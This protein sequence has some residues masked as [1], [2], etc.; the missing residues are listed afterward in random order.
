M[1]DANGVLWIRNDRKPFAKVTDENIDVALKKI[2]DVDGNQK[3][4]N[5]SGLKSWCD[6]SLF[7][8]DELDSEYS[9]SYDDGY[10]E[11]KE[12]GE[13]EGFERAKSD[14]IDIIADE[15]D[16]CC[17]CEKITNFLDELVEKIKGL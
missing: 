6:D 7:D 9:K 14:I 11:G 13:P 1:G 5:D 8:K 2:K 16:K 4:P 17:N 3:Y 10:D 15:Q 12:D